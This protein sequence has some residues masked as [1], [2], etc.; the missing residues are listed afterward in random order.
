MPVP[1]EYRLASLDFERFLAE[2]SEETGLA[3]L[4]P[5]V[6]AFWSRAGL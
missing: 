3:T 2:V 5:E 4:S 6:R 1:M